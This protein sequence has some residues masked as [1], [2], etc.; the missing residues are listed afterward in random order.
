[1][2]VGPRVSDRGE[3]KPPGQRGQTPAFSRRRQQTRR[4]T[5][6]LAVVPRSQRGWARSRAQT[7]ARR[8][9]APVGP[10][11]A[12]GDGEELDRGGRSLGALGNGAA[13][14]VEWRA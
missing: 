7:S 13:V 1:M 5:R 4:G 14:A 10:G 8:A 12:R 11:V 2:G 3:V 9:V 6:A